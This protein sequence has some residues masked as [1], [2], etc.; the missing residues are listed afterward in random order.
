VNRFGTKPAFNRLAT[1]QIIE[2]MFTDSQFSERRSRWIMVVLNAMAR[3][4]ATR[5][6][7]LTPIMLAPVMDFYVERVSLQPK[8][9]GQEKRPTSLAT[10]SGDGIGK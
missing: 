6:F 10:P 7:K 9:N 4:G 2:R 5:L 3:V 8:D 1:Y